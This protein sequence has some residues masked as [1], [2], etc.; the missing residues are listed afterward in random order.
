MMP[1]LFANGTNI[2]HSGSDAHRIQQE[3]DTDLIQ[4]SQWL[5]VN[6]L[7]LNVKKTNFMVFMNKN[8][9]KPDIVLRIDGYK[10]NKLL[11]PKFLGV[12]IDC[13][14]T[15]K[16]INYISGNFAKGIGIHRGFVEKIEY[17]EHICNKQ[18][19]GR[20]TSMFTLNYDV[21][22]LNTRQVSHFHIPILRKEW[23]KSSI[24]YLGAV[25]WNDIMSNG[26]DFLKVRLYLLKTQGGKYS[27]G[28]CEDLLVKL[29]KMVLVHG[30]WYHMV[31]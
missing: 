22:S 17:F 26:L 9:S 7:S 29:G 19:F 18:I 12:I 14:L 4:I 13:Q 28:Y 3:I 2:F 31:D 1:F 20:F 24:F 10:M 8:S 21:H 30:L 23:R 5:K 15:W 11:K 6:K 27:M 25:T 16:Y